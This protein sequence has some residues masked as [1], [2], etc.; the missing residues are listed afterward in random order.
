MFSHARLTVSANDCSD[1]EVP[2]QCAPLPHRPMRVA[3]SRDSCSSSDV[4]IINLNQMFLRARSVTLAGSASMKIA[5]G[6]SFKSL[7][8]SH[9]RRTPK[10]EMPLRTHRREPRNCACSSGRIGL[11]RARIL[12]WRIIAHG[13][14]PGHPHGILF[15]WPLGVVAHRIWPRF[16]MRP[17]ACSR[18]ARRYTKADRCIVQTASCFVDAP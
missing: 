5:L 11:S 14:A 18:Y 10:P 15:F 6:E 1:I 3:G 12:V 4:D 13:T 17:T 7:G 9:R 8:F 16:R 2:S